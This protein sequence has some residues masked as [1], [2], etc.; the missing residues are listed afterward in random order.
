MGYES[1]LR[2]SNLEFLGCLPAQCINQGIQLHPKACRHHL[3]LPATDAA[4]PV[5]VR[6][7]WKTS[8]WH[9]NVGAAGAGGKL[10]AAGT[11]SPQH[12]WIEQGHLSSIGPAFFMNFNKICNRIPLFLMFKQ[13]GFHKDNRKS[14]LQTGIP[15]W[16]SPGILR[17]QR[18]RRTTSG[19]SLLRI[20]E[21][22]AWHIALSEKQKNDQWLESFA[23]KRNPRTSF[24]IF[25]KSDSKA[26][27]LNV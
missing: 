6:R 8:F 22:F 14:W 12:V 1:S 5:V 13:F 3:E 11:E 4:L 17:F 24:Q 18:N 21:T 10:G 16:L 2:I 7:M 27:V 9:P 26:Q 19:W 25:M 15:A 20:K 23:H